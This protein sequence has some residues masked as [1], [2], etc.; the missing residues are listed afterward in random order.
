ML[1]E[2]KIIVLIK[3]KPQQLKQLNSFSHVLEQRPLIK[4]KIDDMVLLYLVTSE[5]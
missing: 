5:G 3:G 2:I 4:N 1:Q